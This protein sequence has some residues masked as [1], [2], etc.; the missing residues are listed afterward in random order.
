VARLVVLAPVLGVLALAAGYAATG[1]ARH[2]LAVRGV[3][4]VPNHRSSHDRMVPR[5]GGVVIVGVAASV[6]LVGWSLS[7]W[8]S[9]TLVVVAGV[10]FVLA[11]LGLIDDLKDLPVRL[12]LTV[13]VGLCSVVAITVA[14]A[15]ETGPVTTV[16]MIL[17][18]TVFLVG[19]TNIYNFMDGIDGIAGLTALAFALPAATVAFS[20]RADPEGVFITVLAGGTAGFLVHNWSPARIF[21]GD[22]GSLFLGFLATALPLVLAVRDTRGLLTLGALIPFL[23]DGTLTILRRLRRGDRLTDAHRDHV[24]Q[25]A[26]RRW[27]HAPVAAAY[28]LVALAIAALAVAAGWYVWPVGAVVGLALALVVAAAWVRLSSSLDRWALAVGG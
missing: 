21:M 11:A 16:S 28:G 5:G 3:V 24:Y 23:I 18:G 7:A 22:S 9:L 10:G 15:A 6:T 2:Q 12:R 4:D 27:G 1:W 19:S 13:Q 20:V 26:S 8:P 17:M 14:R 25:R